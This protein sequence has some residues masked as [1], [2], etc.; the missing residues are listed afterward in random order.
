MY[1][2]FRQTGKGIVT[3]KTDFFAVSSAVLWQ[4]ASPLKDITA[5]LLLNLHNENR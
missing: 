2:W 1:I 4:C 5:V 3:E